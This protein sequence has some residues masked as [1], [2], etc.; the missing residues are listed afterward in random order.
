MALSL[1]FS[2]LI[3]TVAALTLLEWF[4]RPARSDWWINLQAWALMLV[5]GLTV[6]L[7]FEMPAVP[8]LLDGATLPFWL[9]FPAFLIVSDLGEYLFHRAQHCIPLLWA[10]HSL[11]HSDPDMSALTTQRHFWAD[12]LIKKIT[13]WAATSFII[14]PTPQIAGATAIATLWSFFTHA[15]LPI[16]FGRWSWL[17]NTPAYHRRHHSAL[18]EHYDSNFAALFPIFDLICG[19]YYR[20]DGFPPTGFSSAPRNLQQLVAW[21]LYH[22]Q[23]A[24]PPAEAVAGA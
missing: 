1:P 19:S 14:A 3:D 5:T 7:P 17:I 20:P 4:G 10:M 6:H 13:I 15:R 23:G 21:P 9:G 12:P 11:H 24:S 22:H 8:S 18:P 2:P 16:D